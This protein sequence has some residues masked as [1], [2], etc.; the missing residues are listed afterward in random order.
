MKSRMLLSGCMA[1]ALASAGGAGATSLDQFLA[2]LPSDN[3]AGF[4]AANVIDLSAYQTM[5]KW[6]EP[7][8][9]CTVFSIVGA[10]E[11]AYTHKYCDNK[12]SNFYK[13]GYCQR[14]EALKTAKLK[15]FALVD[16]AWLNSDKKALDLSEQYFLN[17]V[18]SMWVT[19]PASN[20]ESGNLFC[21]LDGVQQGVAGDTAFVLNNLTLPE[22]SQ[23]PY[24]Y[25]KAFY[26][27]ATAAVCQGISQDK[28]DSYHF[29]ETLYPM[30]DWNGANLTRML[31]PHAGYQHAAF[32]AT[33]LLIVHT[34]AFPDPTKT[35]EKILYSGREVAVSGAQPGHSMLLTGYDRAAKKFLFKD[36]YQRWVTVGYA[37]LAKSM[38]E[39]SV[40]MDVRADTLQP[41]R[42]EMWLGPWVMDLDGRLGKLLIRR[43]QLPSN[44]LY[45]DDK[46]SGLNL[47]RIPTSKWARVGTFFE[48]DTTKRTVYGRFNQ[49]DG[50]TFEL[51]V[52]FSKV[53]G[54][55]DPLDVVAQ[56]YQPTG[57][58][59]TLRMFT[60]GDGAASYAIG[61]AMSQGKPYGVLLRRP[62]E[63]P[64]PDYA[65]VAATSFSRDQWAAKFKVVFERGS[66]GSLEI[67]SND[68]FKT[69]TGQLVNSTNQSSK[70]TGQF[71]A[72]NHV[73]FKTEGVIAVDY[74]LFYHT[75][76]KGVLSGTATTYFGSS[77][78]VSP[79]YAV[80]A[81]GMILA[82]P[83][84]MMTYMPL[85]QTKKRATFIPAMDFR[86]R[87]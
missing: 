73:R 59:I 4:K 37:D 3:D 19:S 85:N 71:V 39:I 81:A 31:T 28:I 65:H 57:Q 35:L 12:T 30:K 15:P 8:G 87:P 38:Y 43:N 84:L 82:K 6:Q 60:G 40:V 58:T 29:S 64:Y 79:L 77:P 36:H 2:K 18:L 22:E 5:S 61:Q 86:R 45:N 75:W 76:E 13:A 51:N 83:P 16:N 74:D 49:S 34:N 48:N 25:D 7:L 80:A 70:V 20:H 1:L 47:T 50:S 42:E 53:E 41:S 56:G 24:I 68:G 44:A 66:V 27:K 33:D 17:R 54:P 52:D 26:D 62:T 78:T 67:A 23:V 55:A 21:F 63:R 32:G 72:D 14:Y 46:T 11:A 69:L 9:S 10:V